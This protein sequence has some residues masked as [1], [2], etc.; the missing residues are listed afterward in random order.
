MRNDKRAAG[1]WRWPGATRFGGFSPLEG[2]LAVLRAIVEAPRPWCPE[3]GLDDAALEALVA[4]GVVLRWPPPVVG[5]MELPQPLVTLTAWG[6]WGCGVE[7][8]E[9]D[10]EVPRW[11]EIREDGR[12]RDDGK[13][14]RVPPTDRQ[15]R[16]P[17]P[18]L[19]AD[20]RPGPDPDA[21]E[22]EYLRDEWSGEPVA[23]FAGEDGA[24]VPVVVDPR[25]KGAGKGPRRA[26]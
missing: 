23:L 22:P 1:R 19:V 9:S 13:P 16:L 26:G 3:V 21:D 25:L 17:L 7:V 10:R 4:L 18:A 12:R 15:V 20:L 11:G 14:I 2:S 6:A 8:V 5:T 24:G